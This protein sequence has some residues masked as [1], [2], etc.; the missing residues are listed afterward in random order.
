M[1]PETTRHS[2]IVWPRV[3]SPATSFTAAYTGATRS[4]DPGALF[5]YW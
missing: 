1:T 3:G 4:D 2:H 5:E